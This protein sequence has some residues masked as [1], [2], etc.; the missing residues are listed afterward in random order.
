MTPSRVRRLTLSSLAF[1]LLLL[2]ATSPLTTAWLIQRQAAGIV[3]DSLRG[4]AASSLANL[5]VSEGFL[6]VALALNAPDGTQQQQHF[7]RLTNATYSVDQQY[8]AY[9]TTLNSPA[10]Q[11]AFARVLQHREAYRQSRQA[12]V[13]LA[14]RG[15]LES[16]R[17]L[18][19]SE[20]VPRFQDYQSSLGAVVDHAASEAQRRGARILAICRV[21]L[22]VQLVLLLFF[23]VYAFFVPFV[24]FLER[25]T[26]KEV[27]GEF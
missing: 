18:F 25:L 20:C 15:E 9:R 1:V 6:Q 11:D 4:L 2:I 16:A 5:S 27:S 14:Q 13:D 3:N 23:F 24:T 12:V 10:E 17:R 7:V 21:F 8:D 22:V 26:S 19:Q